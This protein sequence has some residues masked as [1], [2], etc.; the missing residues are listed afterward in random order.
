[1]RGSVIKRNK[2]WSYVL[3]LGRD[4]DGKKRQ[5][6]VG[7]FR[8]KRDAESALTAALER[9]RTGTWAD[10][11][12]L[13]V[14]A[15]LEQWIPG[16]RSTVRPKTAAS[17]EDVLR[18]LVI[19]HI[20]NLRLGTVAPSH[21]RALHS[22][23]L[24]SGRRN[25]RGGG[26]SARSVEYT[27]RILSRALSDAVNDGLLARN[28]AALVRPPRAPKPVTRAWSVG[29][30]RKFLDG[31]ADDRLYAMW[32]LL[33]TT[34]LRRGEALGLRWEDVDLERGRLAVRHTAVAIGYE[35]HVAEPK[36]AAGRR[37][38]SL[39]PAT[40]ATLKAHH[41]N[42]LE[43]RLRIG[44]EWND[45]GIVFTNERGSMI[46]PDRVSKVFPRLIAELELPRIRL[47]DLRHT[48][49][50]LALVA[51]VHPKVV[52]E[53]LGHANIAIT[54]DTYSHVVDGLHEDAAALVGDLIYGT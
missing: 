42:Q 38:V 35:V 6:W 11:G 15:Y 46:H 8:T 3:Y 21:I 20:G 32:A 33:V 48:A 49:A 13:T 36:T 30:V 7:G 1:M 28:P 27:H 12:Q 17:Y 50:T 24:E 44:P 31:V 19:P 22:E 5:K 34:G 9:M 18:G 43:E 54:L 53:R 25:G 45:S 51:G 40:V 41:R 23:L 10:A 37:T 26:L 16:M 14:G 2:T 47:H 29:D 52:Q 4:A 39:D